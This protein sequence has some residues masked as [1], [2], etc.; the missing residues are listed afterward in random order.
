MYYTKEE[1]IEFVKEN[2]VRFIR[3]AFCDGQ[4]KLKNISVYA[5]RVEEIFNNGSLINVYSVY[6]DSLSLSKG[7]E[8]VLHPDPT[9]LT[10]LP[11][12]PSSGKVVRFFCSITHPDGTPFEWDFRRML[13]EVL[14][15]AYRKKILLTVDTCCEFYLFKSDENGMRTK[16]PLDNASYLDTSPF[17]RGENIRREI[18]LTLGEMGIIPEH[19]YHEAG[20]GQNE[21][22]FMCADPLTAADNF[23]TFKNVVGSV[24]GQYGLWASFEPKPESDKPGNSL[25][26]GLRVSSAEGKNDVQESFCAGIVSHL[27]EIM[28][29]LNTSEN[30]FNSV[31]GNFALHRAGY[32]EKDSRK[33]VYYP[34]YEGRKISVFSCDPELDMY[35]ALSVIILAGIDGIDKKLTL[36]KESCLDTNPNGTGRIP[37]SFDEAF[38]I[39]E[40]S[41]FIKSAF[42]KYYE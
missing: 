40:N 4:G 7:S 31:F 38:E 27:P 14:S 39:S 21:I 37:L 25:H 32:S 9:T 3:L 18:C 24:S 19:S 35:R 28:P 26:I 17:D 10:L 8:L 6:G 16:T 41:E 23:V 5:S 36:D 1:A 30:A 42:E 15:D 2:D 13:K 33:I 11:W 12:R 22:D 29:Y 34:N 20:P